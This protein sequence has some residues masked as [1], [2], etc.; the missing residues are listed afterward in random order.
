[1]SMSV[2]TQVSEKSRLFDPPWPSFHRARLFMFLR[3]KELHT[4]LNVKFHRYRCLLMSFLSAHFPSESLNINLFQQSLLPKILIHF[5]VVVLIALT[6]LL[7]I[8]YSRFL[9]SPRTRAPKG[10]C[11]RNTRPDFPRRSGDNWLSTG[12]RD[13]H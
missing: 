13:K 9:P 2:I 12:G 6:F 10:V 5:C 3:L 11:L 7:S 8:P 1:M 4:Y